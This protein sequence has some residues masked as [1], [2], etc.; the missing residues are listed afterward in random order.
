MAAYA[1]LPS[2]LCTVVPI[3]WIQGSEG[4]GKSNLMNVFVAIHQIKAQNA[5][6]SFASI[7]N[8]IATNSVEDNR[9]EKHFVLCV[10]N[11][12]DEKIKNENI[13]TLLWCVYD[14]KDAI[15][16]AGDNMEFN[17]FCLKVVTTVHGILAHPKFV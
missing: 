17:T 5:S 4:S 1:S 7:P 8:E 13:Y 2:D 10:D 14:R 16:A 9:D 12:N 11:L 6:G 3:L 15:T